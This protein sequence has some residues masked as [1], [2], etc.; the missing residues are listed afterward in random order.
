MAAPEVD[1]FGKFLVNSLR[2]GA[3]DFF[4]GLARGDWKSSS[5]QDLQASLAS[6]TTD[7]REIVRQCVATCVDYGMHNFLMALGES[8]FTKEGVQVRVDGKDVA[9]LSDGLEA[10][11]CGT[12]GW[13]AKFSKYP[14]A[15]S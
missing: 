15:E 6:L 4:D 2:D 3:L 5:T 13:I 14:L 9:E 8:L 1:K 12:D 10:E 11:P 7:Q